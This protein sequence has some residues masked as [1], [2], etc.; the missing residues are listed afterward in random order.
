MAAAKTE[1]KLLVEDLV[2]LFGQQEL[3]WPC[4][5]SFSLC[6]PE[7]GLLRLTSTIRSVIAI[8]FGFTRRPDVRP[9]GLIWVYSYFS[10][11]SVKMRLQDIPSTRI[12]KRVTAMR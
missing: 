2:D 7:S 5:V 11:R 12:K 1:N 6:W 9:F 8:E 10:K 3:R 4:L